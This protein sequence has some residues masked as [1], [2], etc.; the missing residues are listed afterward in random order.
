[1]T[2]QQVHRDPYETCRAFLETF[3]EDYEK[4]KQDLE[5]LGEQDNWIR[6]LPKK[7]RRRML[8]TITKSVMTYEEMDRI[9][10]QFEEAGLT[11]MVN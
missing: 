9:A 4:H 1:M 8:L 7:E 3:R 6:A 11:R 10:R 2:D 5:M